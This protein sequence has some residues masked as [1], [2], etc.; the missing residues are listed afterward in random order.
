M[1]KVLEPGLKY[2]E[3]TQSLTTIQGDWTGLVH[4]TV[5]WT[6]IYV[7]KNAFVMYQNVTNQLSGLWSPLAPGFCVFIKAHS[8]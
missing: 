5:D 7:K 6:D 2:P 3:Q 4:W 1:I 8:M